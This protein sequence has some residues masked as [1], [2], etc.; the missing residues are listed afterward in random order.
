MA[1]MIYLHNIVRM[2][3]TTCSKEV[4]CLHSFGTTLATKRFFEPKPGKEEAKS[5]GK[6]TPSESGH[7]LAKES[8]ESAQLE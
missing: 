4:S 8:K 7:K 3:Q 2:E 6:T 1:I 5:N